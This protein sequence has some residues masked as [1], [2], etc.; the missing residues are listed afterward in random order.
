MGHAAWLY[1]GR[2][3]WVVATRTRPRAPVGSTVA[4]GLSQVDAT[5][6][7]LRSTAQGSRRG[8]RG[9]WHGYVAGVDTRESASST[10][11]PH[12]PS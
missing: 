11:G 7:P 4:G 6:F 8:C 2:L 12:G 3:S 5:D 1:K 10:Q 9:R